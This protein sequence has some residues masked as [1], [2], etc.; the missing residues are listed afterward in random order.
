MTLRTVARARDGRRERKAASVGVTVEVS[1]E[2]DL[3]GV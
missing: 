3:C 1:E 2:P